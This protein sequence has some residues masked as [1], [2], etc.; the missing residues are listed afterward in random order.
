MQ[1]QEVANNLGVTPDTVR[2][3]TRAGLLHPFKNTTNGYNDYDNHDR[4]RLHFILSARH[5]GF[6][7]TRV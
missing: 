1:V 2:Y 7:L 6:G 5:L 4:H 3:Y